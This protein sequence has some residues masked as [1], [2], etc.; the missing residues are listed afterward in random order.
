[1][2]HLSHKRGPYCWGGR[3]AAHFYSHCLL[4]LSHW[5]HCASKSRSCAPE[6]RLTAP[7]CSLRTM[8]LTNGS[9]LSAWFSSQPRC[10]SGSFLR[11]TYGFRWDAGGWFQNS[12]S[13]DERCRRGSQGRVLVT[14]NEGTTPGSHSGNPALR[15]P[16]ISSF[17]FDCP[18]RAIH[19]EIVKAGSVSSTQAAASR[20]SAS[21]PRWAKADARQQ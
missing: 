21:R 11:L 5:R 15:R 3:L 7:A 2:E 10:V 17:A 1:M 20:A 4:D 14:G 13:K 9:D 8:R 19:E 18:P 12:P 16:S 6:T